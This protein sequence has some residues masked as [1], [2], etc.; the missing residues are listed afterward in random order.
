M[1]IASDNDADVP[2]GVTGKRDF[3]KLLCREGDDDTDG[4]GVADGKFRCKI[5]EV[6]AMVRK[7]SG[8]VNCAE[9]RKSL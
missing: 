8:V 7:V 2:A 3:A 6:D 4:E 1:N 5:P 9:T